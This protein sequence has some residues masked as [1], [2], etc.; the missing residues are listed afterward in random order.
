MITAFLLV[1]LSSAEDRNN[2]DED[3]VTLRFNEKKEIA[4]KL[5]DKLHEKF[6]DQLRISCIM[7]FCDKKG[8]SNLV[9]PE[10]F[11]IRKFLAMEF[12]KIEDI[13][14]K[15]DRALFD[16]IVT[17]EIA[18]WGYRVGY[19]ECLNSHKGFFPDKYCEEM[20]KRIDEDISKEKGK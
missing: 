16:A 12:G 15:D 18:M 2:A 3:E 7:H 6:G 9:L 13:K 17:A 14:F 11:E 8:F 19:I 20:L 4:V 5:F 1:G 10:V